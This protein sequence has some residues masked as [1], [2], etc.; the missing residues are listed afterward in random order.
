L[1]STRQAVRKGRLPLDDMVNTTLITIALGLLMGAAI[2]LLAAERFSL[3]PP[4]LALIGFRCAK[5]PA[6]LAPATGAPQ[7]AASQAGAHP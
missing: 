4:G 2:P 5:S 3:T 7:A 6:P 1:I